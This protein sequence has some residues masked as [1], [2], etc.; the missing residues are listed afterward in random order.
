MFSCGLNVG[1]CAID[2]DVVNSALSVVKVR[3]LG[4]G[5]SAPPV[6]FEPPAIV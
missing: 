6:P 5:G 4:V 1:V 3:G 2:D